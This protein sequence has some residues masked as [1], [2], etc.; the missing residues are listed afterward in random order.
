VAD[1][2]LAIDSSFFKSAGTFLVILDVDLR[3]DDRVRHFCVQMES[4]VSL[5]EFVLLHQVAE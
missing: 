3:G 4:F 2:S 1:Y 5:L